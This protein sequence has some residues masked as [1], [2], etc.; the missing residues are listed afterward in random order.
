MIRVVVARKSRNKSE[1]IQVGLQSLLELDHRR[2]LVNSS[3]QRTFFLP[4]T[5]NAQTSVTS[6]KK[7]LPAMT[8]ALAATIMAPK[9]SV[10]GSCKVE[11]T[12]SRLQVQEVLNT[13]IHMVVVILRMMGRTEK[14]K[15]LLPNIQLKKHA[16]A[17]LWSL[18]KACFVLGLVATRTTLKHHPQNCR[19]GS[20]LSCKSAILLRIIALPLLHH[21]LLLRLSLL[22]LRKRRRRRRR[23][24]KS[25][26]KNVRKVPKWRRHRYRSLKTATN[27]R[28]F[29]RR[30]TRITII[31]LNHDDFFLA[32][33]N[34][35]KHER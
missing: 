20:C 21:L 8:V 9:R 10:L 4:T 30:P 19:I 17:A 32:Q 29:I 15:T 2:R 33:N 24:R 31:I 14:K 23:R 27:Q 11:M 35:C 1:Q 22:L 3:K 6:T 5:T 13:N 25:P 34:F 26:R 12:P 18:G 16:A 28:I 7:M